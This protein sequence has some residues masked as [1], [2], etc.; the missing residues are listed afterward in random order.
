MVSQR[1]VV[2]TVLEHGYLEFLTTGNSCRYL[3]QLQQQATAPAREAASN[4]E[5]LTCVDDTTQ[6]FPQTE[7]DAGGTQPCRTEDD[8]P[9]PLQHQPFQT[10]ISIESVHGHLEASNPLASASCEYVS[11]DKGRLRM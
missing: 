2:I 11:D 6:T 7:N 8:T 5:D 9:F 10:P 1:S 3:R 4:A